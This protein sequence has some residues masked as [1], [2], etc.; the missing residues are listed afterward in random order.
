[1]IDQYPLVF[2]SHTTLQPSGIEY[3]T[4]KVNHDKKS[5]CWKNIEFDCRI[6]RDFSHKTFLFS[7]LFV[8]RQL[9]ERE[10]LHWLCLF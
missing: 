2:E 6:S 4:F 7:F 9:Y 10:K 5:I 3:Q 8:N 1:M